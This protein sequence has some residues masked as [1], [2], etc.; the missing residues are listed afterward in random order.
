MKIKKNKNGSSMVLVLVATGVFFVIFSS[1]ISYGLIKQKFNKMKIASTQAF[2]I[3]EAGIDYYRWILYHDSNH[4]STTPPC[5][6]NYN[7]SDPDGKISGSYE[8]TV[9]PTSS[10]GFIVKSVGRVD[11]YPNLKRTIEVELAPISW[12]D[13]L[14]ISNSDLRITANTTISGNIHSNGGIRFDGVASAS[15]SFSSGVPSYFDQSDEDPYDLNSLV[16]FSI[17]THV[18]ST[19][20]PDIAHPGASEPNNRNLVFFNGKFS[21]VPKI[22]FGHELGDYVQEMFVL[23]E[24]EHD[25]SNGQYTFYGPSTDYNL[26][27]KG[28]YFELMPNTYT[29]YIITELETPCIVGDDSYEKYTVKKKNQIGLNNKPIPEAG[30][31]FV[32]DNIWV[33]RK[34]PGSEHD[35]KVTLLAFKEPLAGQLADITINDNFTYKDSEII[36][37]RGIGLIAQGNINIGYGCNNDIEIA[38]G[39]IAKTGRIG[40][41]NY[42][43]GCGPDYQK[44]SIKILGSMAS[45]GEYGLSFPDTGSGFQSIY[46]IYDESF[47]IFGPPPNFP[48]TGEY[49]IVSW[50][51]Q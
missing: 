34:N 49:R 22:N 14:L 13:Y 8:L 1:A 16:D 15:S 36:G 7:Y 11:A 9:T 43:S 31:I 50:K 25:P 44:N 33:E 20:Y 26:N 29:V 40:R 48:T 28:Y 51:E 6:F 37:D 39:I 46:L 32:Q 2:N 24:G 38:S 4:C 41:I 47:Q 21:P 18:T 30:I 5:V 3:A 17:H 12:S 42:P 23:A 19:E 45:Y 27:A 35:P 10:S